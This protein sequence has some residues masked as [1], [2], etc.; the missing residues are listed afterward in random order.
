VLASALEITF[1]LL[2]G[3]V[4]ILAGLFGLYLLV[5]LF[6]NPSRR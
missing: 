5:Q 4:T 2:V 1:M 3:G 6:R